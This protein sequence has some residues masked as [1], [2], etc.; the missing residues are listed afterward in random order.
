M[1]Q[2]ILVTGAN[3]QLGMEL[4]ELSSAYSLFNFI[5]LSRQELAIE[6]AES[7]KHF[8][9]KNRPQYCINCAAYTAVDKAESEK[10]QE[11]AFLINAEAV[12]IL[13]AACNEQNTILIHISTDFV[14]NGEAAVPYN[15]DSPADPVSI[16]GVSKLEGEKLAL[17]N[18]PRTIIIR[19][20][21]VY[22]SYGKNFVKTMLRLMSEKNEI[23][24]VNDLYGS[25]TYAADLAESILKIINSLKSQSSKLTAHSS[26][27]QAVFI[28]IV[29]MGL[30]VGMILLLR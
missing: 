13:A 27:L 14:F 9:A 28:I 29:M 11:Q 15:E 1:K 23:S 21:W 18:N 26:Q 4:R 8:F 17:Q 16:Y 3:G 10:E 19:T 24:V 12:G 5:F 6:N 30:S 25:P 2:K 22:S 20:S 7:V